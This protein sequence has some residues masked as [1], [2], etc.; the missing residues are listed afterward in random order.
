MRT[1][2]RVVEVVVGLGGRDVEFADFEEI[3]NRCDSVLKGGE[4]PRFELIQVRGGHY[5]EV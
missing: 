3:Y 2:R 1:S 4:V 5:G